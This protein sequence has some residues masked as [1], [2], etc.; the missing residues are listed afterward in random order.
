ME[1]KIDILIISAFYSISKTT[2]GNL[3]IGKIS[4][5]V[6]KSAKI[7]F[8]NFVMNVFNQKFITA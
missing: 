8:V 1:V 5:N 3:D 4:S 2:T 7:K 6:E